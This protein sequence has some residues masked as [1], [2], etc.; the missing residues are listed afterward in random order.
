MK[1]SNI[2]KNAIL[3]ILKTMSSIIFPLITVPY[4]SR[5]L[6]AD[7]VGKINF[8]NSIVS[9]ISLIASL[10]VTTYAIREC[11]RYRE[12]EK[13]LENTASQI[14][15]INIFSTV[16][17]YI[18]LVCLLF[19]GKSL[20]GYVILIIIQSAVIIFTTLGADWINSTMEDFKYLAIRTF[21]VQFVSLIAMFLFVHKPED[22]L[23]YA[24]ISVIAQ[25]GANVINILYRRK[26]CIIRF[27][28]HID[29]K[30]HLPPIMLLFAMIL[31]QQ[32]FVNFDITMIGIMKG[33]FEVGLY[34]TA[35]KI[36]LTVNQVIASI[37]W[38]VMPKLSYLFSEKNYKGINDVLRYTANIICVLGIPVVVGLIVFAPEILEVVAG[39]EYISAATSLRIL[40]GALALSLISGFMTNIILLPSG[41]ERI[42]LISCIISA[43]VNFI[44]NIIFIPKY[45]IN[46]AAFSTAI[47]E[48]VI[49]IVSA[50]YIEKQIEFTYLKTML[51]API[52]GGISI[53]ILCLLSKNVIGN[54]YTRTGVV[55][56]FSIIVYSLILFLFKDKLAIICKNKIVSKISKIKN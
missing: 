51:K 8:G 28:V 45:G 7:N 53:V 10:G 11:S 35:T 4:I 25:S 20:N 19:F 36:Y 50:F 54:V 38:V 16:I 13:Q 1:E 48:V 44:L 33:D 29:W 41:K 2:G 34:S 26:F 15:S 5:V 21:I 52:V 55:I 39:T 3:N 43:F 6:H 24:L 27:T 18:V 47:S 31:A 56:L 23:K 30:R 49:I 17:A 40:A 14:M 32:I 22:Y 9:Y 46:A 37:A 12:N 42:C